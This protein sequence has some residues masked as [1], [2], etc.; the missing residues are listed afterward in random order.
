MLVEIEVES[1]RPRVHQ[2]LEK[3]GTRRVHR[4]QAV[5]IDEQLHPQIAPDLGLARG[6]GEPPL[7][8]DEVRLDTIEVVLGL[9]VHEPEDGVG[10]GLP[11]DVGDAEVITRDGDVLGLG[12]PTL[13]VGVGGSA[14]ARGEDDESD[15]G[16]ESVHGPTGMVSGS[17][18]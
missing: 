11:V 16:D 14:R 10:V 2:G 17:I 5:R 9:G 3:L 15:C 4:L 7:R 12:F 8:V 13:G 1:I 18:S 6:L